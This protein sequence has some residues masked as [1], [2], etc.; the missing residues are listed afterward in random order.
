MRWVV[1]LRKVVSTTVVV[2]VVMLVPSLVELVE[3]LELEPTW[4]TVVS[5]VTCTELFARSM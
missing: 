3:E 2:V 1:T 5:V 4:V